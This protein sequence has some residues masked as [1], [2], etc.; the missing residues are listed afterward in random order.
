MTYYIKVD[1]A[2]LNNLENSNFHSM[3]FMVENELDHYDEHGNLIQKGS[4]PDWYE[5]PEEEDDD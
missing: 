1:Q 5:W 2:L 4:S 3:Q